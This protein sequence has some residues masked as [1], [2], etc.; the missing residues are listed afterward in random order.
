MQYLIASIPETEGVRI[1]V[2]AADNCAVAS[3]LIP[4]DRDAEAEGRTLAYADA[5][6]RGIARE[7]VTFKYK[8]MFDMLATLRQIDTSDT[9]GISEETIKDLLVLQYIAR[10]PPGDLRQFVVTPAGIQAAGMIRA[11]PS[12]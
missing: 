5:Q 2:T 8:R 3:A 6:R 7:R 1:R 12:G 4:D 11:T 10:A 9:K